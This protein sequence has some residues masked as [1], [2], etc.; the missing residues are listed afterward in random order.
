VAESFPSQFGIY[1]L[2][3]FLG[4]ISLFGEPDLEFDEKTVIIKEGQ[5]SVKYFAS[6]VENLT[7]IPTIKSFPESDITFD[8]TAAMITQIQRVSS[9]LKVE[10][11]SVIGD[12]STTRLQ[13]GNKSNVT[14]NVYAANIGVTNSV[15]R[16]NFKVE[17]LKIIAGD[18]TVC[19]GGKKTS[20]FKSSTQDIHYFIAIEADSSFESE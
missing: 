4:V 20:R 19:I 14:G 7:K 5:N 10:D 11:F 2:N 9:V 18:Y 6:R 12:G 1:D 8:L 15:F 3:E 16:V 13:V 17:N